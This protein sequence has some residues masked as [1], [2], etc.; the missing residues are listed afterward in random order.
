MFAAE[1]V[2]LPLQLRFLDGGG[3]STKRILERDWS[4]HVLGPPESW[5]D[6]LK[7]SLSTIL[8]SP[9]SLILAWGAEDLTF[10]FN[11]SY[12]RLL[13]P[14]VTWA[15]GSP[16]RQVWADAWEQAAPI[17]ADAFAG[18]S[19]RFVDLPWKLATDRGAA[20]TWF[21][22]SYSRVLDPA[23]EI[24]GLF[25]LTNE[26]TAQVLAETERSATEAR[27]RESEAR[28]RLMADAVPQIVWITDADGRAEFFN[29]QWTRYTGAAYEPTTAA[30]IATGF[31]HPDDAAAT[32]AAFDAAR[33]AGV[34][35]DVEHRIRAAD[36]SYRWFLV[37]AEPYRDPAS[38]TITRW[39]GASVDIH[40]RRVAEAAQ[41]DG[42]ARLREFADTLEQQ[43]ATRTAERDRMW[44]TSP[45]LM[46]EGSLEGVY[47][48]AN[49]AWKSVLGYEPEDVLGRS[50]VDFIHPDDMALMLGGLE[51]VRA[52]TLPSLNLRFRHKDGHYRWIQWV[53]ATSFGLIFAIGRDVTLAIEAEEQL[54]R[55]EEALR[56]S[57]KM[58]AVGQLTGG[59]AHDFNNLLTI[60]RS[61]IDFLRRPDLPPDRRERYLDAASETVGRAAKLTGQLL[62]FAR[63]QALKP[64]TFDVVAR[65]RAVADMLDTVTGARVRVVTTVP[66]A[67]CFVRADVS[68]FETALVNMA[69]NARDA[70]EGE[71]VLT[72]EVACDA[73]MPAIRGHAGS[74]ERFAAVRVSDTGAGIAPDQLPRI[75]EPFYTTKAVGKGTGLGL[76]QVFGFAKQSGGDISVV[77][78]PGEG[79]AFTLYIPQVDGQGAGATGTA[80]PAGEIAMGDGQI[81]LVVEDNVEVG[82]FCTQILE[83]LGYRTAWAM[84]A[85]EALERLGGDGGGFDA[86]FSDVVMPGM[87]GLALARVLRERWPDLPL[88]LTS[89][90]SHVLSQDH[91]HGFELLHKP[92]SAEQVADALFRVLRRAPTAV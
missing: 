63:R 36:G 43:V 61:S 83:D 79:A 22:F 71:G 55:T 49:P 68:Q 73:G 78:T 82:R 16:F 26:T 9:E 66:D 27:L 84:N 11:D 70:M 62:A 7:S 29:R 75:F 57:Q 89:G 54:R 1:P 80:P 85:E 35:F 81:I 72:V 46:V 17:I 67:A 33:Q 42:E 76:S 69:V 14:R 58:E 5:P 19:Q 92:Y 87:G 59:V 28:F 34:T 8:N 15:M 4:D 90:Y 32:M 13:G 38:G 18:R 25:I 65:V 20:E 56:Q 31:V 21:T 45:D 86:V 39:F 23:G 10:F 3:R 41:R 74:S 24:A 12:E 53:A 60:I 50:A 37:R 40:D 47:Q 2:A 51:T 52:D 6:I 91:E 30:G 44:N 48:R 64:E 77:S 88:V